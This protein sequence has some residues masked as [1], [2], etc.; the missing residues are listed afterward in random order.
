MTASDGSQCRHV[1]KIQFN[2]SARRWA[3][4]DE[5]QGSGN[6]SL[7]WFLHLPPHVIAQVGES[8]ILLSA[9]EGQALVM[10]MQGLSSQDV[11]IEKSWYSP[12]YGAKVPTSRIHLA[13]VVALPY[14]CAFEF[15]L[16][17]PEC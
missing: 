15:A 4:V 13:R 17:P 3:V 8:Q 12:Q 6:H 10:T 9:T 14:S 16:Q 1:R 7:D 5:V 2:K 11:T